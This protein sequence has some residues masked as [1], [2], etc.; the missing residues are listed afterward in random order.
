MMLSD[1]ELLAR[2]VGFDS[3][4]SRSNALLAEFLGGYLRDSN[5]AVER[6][7]YDEGRKVN[8]IARR[9][10]VSDGGLI[11][12]G[13]MDVVPADEPD[14]NSNPFELT[15]RDGR[16]YGRGSA[17]M[18]SWIAQAVS[19]LC[20]IRENEL[21]RPL[22]L[23][24]TADEE[25]GSIGMQRLL[26]HWRAHP[27]ASLPKQA[28]IG[29]PTG[30]RAIRMHKG[31]L[32]ARLSAQGKPAHSGYPHLGVNAIELAGAALQQLTRLAAEL[33]SHRESTSVRFADCPFPA[34][35]VGR[36]VGGGAVNVVPERCE[37]EFG[38]RL[39][40][41]QRREWIQQ[42][43][44][45]ALAELPAATRERLMLSILNENP[46]M[47]CRDEAPLW[48]MLCGMLKQGEVPGASFA[49]DGGW[50]STLGVD[51]VLWGPG[52][53]EDAHRANESID[54]AEWVRGGEL[55]QQAVRHL[56]GR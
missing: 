56:C 48:R 12:S 21:Q 22:V 54:E 15:P 24:L 51:C 34:L 38:V 2:L 18:K 46:P 31:H 13:H 36:I 3:V 33:R 4:S 23:V 41:G 14:W 50:L 11:L 40:P 16:L 39:L 29:E 8:L 55:L 1:R 42:R 25:L 27:P 53:I 10:P 47:L 17:D 9:G 37:L 28:I 7:E 43:L 5:C 35:N 45:A 44:D 19:L 49:S 32:K 26:A 20:R 6:Q 30:L 52:S